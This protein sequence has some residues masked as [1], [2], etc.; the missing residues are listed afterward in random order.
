MKKNTLLFAAMLVFTSIIT[1]CN[2]EEIYAD[3]NSFVVE[4][5]TSNSLT[6][7]WNFTSNDK[8]L[9]NFILLRDD[10]EVAVLDINV[11]EF[12]DTGLES[13]TEYHYG[14]RLETPCCTSESSTIGRTL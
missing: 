1:S 13:N 5:A 3:T 12:T 2:E 11:R 7:T 14:L 9:K 4:E 6:L 8:D 10:E